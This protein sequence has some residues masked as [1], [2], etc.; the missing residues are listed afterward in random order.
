[1]ASHAWLRSPA[2][3]G[4]LRRGLARYAKYLTL[5]RLYPRHRGGGVF[6]PTLDIDLA[7]HTHLC[8]PKRYASASGRVAGRAVGHDDSLGEGVLADGMEQT[9][10]LYRVR[11]GE[12]Y[13][14]CLCWDCETMRE[15][16]EEEEER[17]RVSV[18]VSVSGGDGDGDG[19]GD[20]EGEGGEVNYEAIADGVSFCVAYYR[21]VEIAR[22]KKKPLPTK[23]E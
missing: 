17:V 9:A 6:V 7:W 18:S 22:R 13:A 8:L 11:F 2:P 12:E 3:R 15:G 19:D 4:T 20:G 5:F 16:V 14:R 1:M 21:A 10:A 23:L